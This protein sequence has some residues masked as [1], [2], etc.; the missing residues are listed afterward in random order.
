MTSKSLVSLAWRAVRIGVDER[1]EVVTRR[2]GVRE[3][4]LGSGP[5]DTIS[6]F[7]VQGFLQEVAAD[8]FVAFL[9]FLVV[10]AVLTEEISVLH[11]RCIVAAERRCW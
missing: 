3:D 11:H 6:A 4:D 9:A 5:A 10:A 2:R 1:R 8:R 7:G